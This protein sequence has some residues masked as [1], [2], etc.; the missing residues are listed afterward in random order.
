MN[1]PIWGGTSTFTAN[2]GE[3]PFSFYDDNSN[4][5]SDAPK[6]ADFVLED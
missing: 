1:I 2:T 4:F 5:V 3:T 6:V